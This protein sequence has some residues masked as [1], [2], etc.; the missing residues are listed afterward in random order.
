MHL[1]AGYQFSQQ[2]LLVP[3]AHLTETIAAAH[4][5]ET[6]AAKF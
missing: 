5:T 4:L 6:I 3:P 1:S 2:E